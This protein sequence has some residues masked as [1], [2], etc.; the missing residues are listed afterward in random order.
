MLATTFSDTI[1]STTCLSVPLSKVHISIS[2]TILQNLIHHYSK[3]HGANIGPI[4]ARQDP[5][6]PHELCYLCTFAEQIIGIVIMHSTQYAKHLPS[7]NVPISIVNFVQ[8]RFDVNFWWI[9]FIFTSTRIPSPIWWHV[10]F[11][12]VNIANL[13]IT[14][15]GEL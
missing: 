3:V 9:S 4:W 12:V 13:F 7:K 1:M 10:I 6:G 14:T 5:G 2:D 15:S 11:L 8:F